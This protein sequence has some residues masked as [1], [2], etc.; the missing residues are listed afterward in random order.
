MAVVQRLTDCPHWFS[1]LPLLLERF[2]SFCSA[3]VECTDL[4]PGTWD[5]EQPLCELVLPAAAAHLK[6]QQQLPTAHWTDVSRY[7][8]AKRCQT[9]NIAVPI[10]DV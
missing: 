3:E 9:R 8:C 2:S 4:G 10:R 7:G 1:F 5:R 6:G